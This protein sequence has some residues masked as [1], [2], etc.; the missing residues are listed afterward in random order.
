MTDQERLLLRKY[1]SRNQSGPLLAETEDEKVFPLLVQIFDAEVAAESLR[2][3]DQA[4][5]TGPTYEALVAKSAELQK[6]VDVE[7]EKKSNKTH[8]LMPALRHESSK[9]SLMRLMQFREHFTNTPCLLI[10]YWVETLQK[11]GAV[12]FSACLF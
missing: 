4:D 8:A 5:R 11:Y 3:M 6:I 10:K 12:S 7:M 2:I 1:L 9:M